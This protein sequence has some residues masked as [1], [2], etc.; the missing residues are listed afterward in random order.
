MSRGRNG[1]ARALGLAAALG[2]IVV[3]AGC[4]PSQG[5]GGSAATI[6]SQTTIGPSRGYTCIDP[7]G[8]IGIDT[9]GSGK[10]SSPAGI[11]I[12]R[13]SAD[14]EGTTLV[15]HFL[16]AGPIAQVR[17]P[18]FDMEQGDISSAPDQSFELRAQ[19]VGN[20]PPSGQWGL[21]LHTFRAGTEA[22]TNL[23]TAV[24]VSGDT[25]TYAVPLSQI[26]TIATL[27]WQF[28]TAS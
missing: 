23:Q 15:V 7:R 20:Q 2:V 18:L 27:Q 3:A 4:S 26:P 13:A 10:L 24:D 11:D 19:P 21:T 16:T 5:G 14:V 1:M 28:G 17:R 12:L 25:L 8:D 22:T 6:G 9:N